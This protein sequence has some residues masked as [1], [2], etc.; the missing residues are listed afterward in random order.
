MQLETLRLQGAL[1]EIERA[2]RHVARF[3]R[4]HGIE[5]EDERIL[6]LIL[7]ELITNTVKHGSPP[8]DAPIEVSLV[9]V[10]SL[11]YPA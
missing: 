9:R 2:S 7:E 1:H 4:T 8:V 6:E 11:E 10:T 5:A 3:C